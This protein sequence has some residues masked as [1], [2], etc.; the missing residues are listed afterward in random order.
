MKLRPLQNEAEVCVELTEPLRAAFAKRNVTVQPLALVRADMG[1]EGELR[2]VWLLFDDTRFFVAVSAPEETLYFST[3]LPK[4]VA[5]PVPSAEISEIVEYPLTG[6]ARPQLIS[7][8]VGGVFS[9]EIEGG[10]RRICRY[11][12]SCLREMQEF[13]GALQQKLEGT[14][15]DEEP[16]RRP[17]SGMHGGGRRDERCP[18]CGRPFPEPGRSVCPHCMEKK[19]V[20]LRILRLFKPYIPQICVMM[21]TIL[22]TGLLNTATP[23]LSGTVLYDKVLG[24]DAAFAE[25]IGVAGNFTALLLGLVFTLAGVRLIQQLGGIVYSRIT[26]SVVPRVVLALKTQV[27]ASLQRLSV[28]FFLRRQTGSLMQRVNGDANNVMSFFIDGLPHVFLNAFTLLFSIIVM[29]LMNWKLAILSVFTLPL[30]LFVNLKLMPYLWRANGRRSST[31]RSLYSV[32]NDSFTGGRV[33]RAFGQ[34][35]YEEKRFSRAN[36]RVRD[37]EVQIVRY[38]NFYSVVHTLASRIPVLLVW[39]VGAWI[40][41]GSSGEF[42]Y[43]ELMTF[44]NYLSMMQGPTEFFCHIFRWWSHSMNAA[45]RVFEIV[46]AHP[47]VVESHDAVDVQIKG[48]IEL[49]HVSFGYDPGKTILKDIDFSVREGE[50]LGIVG[51]SG[52]GKSTLV[53]LISRLY[54]VDEGQIVVEGH[55]IR[56]ISMSSLR[57]A[58]AM[59]SQETFIFMGSIAENIAYSRA[60]ATRDEIVQAAMAAGAHSFICRLPDGYDTVIGTGGRN[61]SGGERQRLSIARA[62]LADPKILVLD[63]ATASVDTETERTIQTALDRLTKGRTTISIAH[64]LS[65]LRG[66]DRLIVLKD[67]KIVESG[68]HEELTA[69]RGEY[70]KLMQLQ[71]KALAMRGVGE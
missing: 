56:D 2:Y 39:S 1:L 28:G 58:V 10:L 5:V 60:D 6:L 62:I 36:D 52:A 46:D 35:A 37:A 51:R 17:H 24:Q 66:A 59:V 13:C 4:G 22:L 38:H 20:M 53:N 61:L 45:Q 16:S 50:M 7:E 34:E 33:V 65:T 54:D 47:D 21:V 25:Q 23:Y 41:L 48:N 70:F 42:A 27:F 15:E 19:T 57:G 69:L 49:R 43:G 32:L 29:F 44:V 18:V 68:T 30:M 8:V 40:I 67:G 14:V 11:S 3:F 12:G 64:R 9:V 55:D 63:E 71:A 26:A 31:M